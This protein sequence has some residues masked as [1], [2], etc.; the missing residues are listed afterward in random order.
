MCTIVESADQSFDHLPLRL[1]TPSEKFKIDH[2][3]RSQAT[4]LQ[5]EVVVE[6]QSDFGESFVYS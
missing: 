3:L 6:E 2:P 1:H 4:Q 5:Q